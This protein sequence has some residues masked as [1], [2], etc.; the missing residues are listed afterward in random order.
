MLSG[1]VRCGYVS[2]LPHQDGPLKV[3]DAFSV[4]P[5]PVL[6]QS[7]YGGEEPAF[8]PGVSQ[9]VR[10]GKR[11]GNRPGEIAQSQAVMDIDPVLY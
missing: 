4:L 1:I 6:R 2:T 9:M 10:S 3:D 5:Y 11:I 7:G 8:Q